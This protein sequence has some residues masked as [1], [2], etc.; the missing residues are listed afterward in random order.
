LTAC[1][2]PEK[3]DVLK[4]TPTPKASP[5]LAHNLTNWPRLTLQPPERSMRD[6]LDGPEAP[7]PECLVG[8]SS[9]A[10][11]KLLG[12][13]DFKRHDSPAEIWQYREASCLLDVFLYSIEDN[14]QVSHVEVRGHSIKEILGTVCLLEVLE[15]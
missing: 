15:N 11:K 8:L 10:I 4:T 9:M 13:P 7:G 1:T 2:A 3:T 6:S 12:R 5:Q 14:Y